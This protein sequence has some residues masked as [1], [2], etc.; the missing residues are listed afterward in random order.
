M[1]SPHYL[2]FQDE[3][4]APMAY[5]FVCGAYRYQL[6]EIDVLRPTL[7]EKRLEILDAAEARILN[8]C[9]T[10]ALYV[11]RADLVDLPSAVR[12]VVNRL[13]DDPASVSW[14][15]FLGLIS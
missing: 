3:K 5:L 6:D 8:F 14:P 2:I 15:E 13:L 7:D 10:L 9:R 1:L 11:D 12:P 4:V